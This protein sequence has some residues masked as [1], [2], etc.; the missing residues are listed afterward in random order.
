[1]TESYNRHIDFNTVLNFRDLG[2]YRTR[3]GYEVSWRKVYRSGEL[4]HIEERDLA[5]LKEEIRLVSVIN[6]RSHKSLKQPEIDLLA[7]AGVR[8][9]VTIPFIN[10][11]NDGDFDKE[12][13]SNAVHMGMLYMYIVRQEGFHGRL[14]KALEFVAEQENHPLVFHCSIGKD[15]T[16]I[17]AAVLLSVL[18]V[19]DE[20]I[21]TDYTL[22]ARHMETFLNRMDQNPEESEEFSKLPAYIWEAEPESMS[23]FLSELRREYGS[24]REFVTSQGGNESLID[25]LKRALLS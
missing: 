8:Q 25:R 12:M 21:I 5:R 11:D 13:F 19:S 6:L 15:R 18:G 24:V 14:V 10:E 2:G 16:G 1:M 20:D 23:Y 7:E 22:T 4:H 3:E 9:H 17:M